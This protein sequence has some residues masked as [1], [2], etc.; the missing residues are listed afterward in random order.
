MDARQVLAGFENG[1]FA[2]YLKRTHVRLHI[3]RILHDMTDSYYVCEILLIFGISFLVKRIMKDRKF[4][5]LF[6][7][8]EARNWQKSKS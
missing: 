2:F 7:G 4:I 6:Y 5:L 1:L 3:D 8:Y